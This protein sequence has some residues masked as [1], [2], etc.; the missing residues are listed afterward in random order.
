MKKIG[1]TGGIGSGKSTVTEYL[2]SLGFH[3]LDADMAAR[4]LVYPDSPVIQELVE[5]F[6]VNILNT[7]GNL[8]RKK[9]A[10]IVFSDAE[11]K[12][13][14]D[15]IMH[16]RIIERLLEKA[17]ALKD[18]KIIFFDVPLLFEVGFERYLDRVWVVDAD[19]EIRI[20]RVMK[21]DGSDRD[22]IV[23]RIAYQLDR[24]ERISKADHILSNNGSKEELYNQINNLL[25]EIR[26]K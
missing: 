17:E 7:N 20:K 3:V 1:I 19:I 4:E 12:S 24:K 10:D 16:K 13:T 11:K 21:R 14:L 22:L 9:L 15:S 23:K 26:E 5:A 25:N 2:I 6:G 18:E 8:D